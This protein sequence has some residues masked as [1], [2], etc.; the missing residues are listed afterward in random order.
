MLVESYRKEFCLPP[1]P[2]AQHLRS[3]AYLDGNIT[4]VLPYL[5]T[6]L[7]AYQFHRDPPSLTLKMNSP[8]SKLRGIKL[9]PE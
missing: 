1:N 3:Y 5:N 6:V 4:E 2:K 8:R 9:P 7:G